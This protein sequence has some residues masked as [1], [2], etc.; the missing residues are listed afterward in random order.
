MNE[1]SS[2]RF[3]TAP[4][5]LLR[6]QP[7]KLAESLR[8][9]CRGARSGPL[10][11]RTHNDPASRGMPA[12]L[13]CV[14]GRCWASLPVAENIQYRTSTSNE[15]WRPAPARTVFIEHCSLLDPIFMFSGVPAPPSFSLT[16][17]GGTP[18]TPSRSPRQQAPA[19]RDVARR[20]NVDGHFVLA[21]HVESAMRAD[22]VVEAPIC[23]EVASKHSRRDDASTGSRQARE[24]RKPR[25][26][27]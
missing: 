1:A 25:P 19:P 18:L 12:W 27:S 20:R 8:S 24:E 7:A 16:R 13:V 11:G 5:R 17:G 14:E 21:S 6:K 10:E 15:E 26:A 22:V 9:W 23:S 4:S 2:T 3:M